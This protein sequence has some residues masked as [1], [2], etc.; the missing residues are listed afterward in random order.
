MKG[1]MKVLLIGLIVAYVVSPMDIPG[2]ID[3]VIVVLLG[4]AARKRIGTAG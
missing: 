3:D 1:F 2:P 4:L